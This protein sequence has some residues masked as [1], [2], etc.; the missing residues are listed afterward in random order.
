VHDYILASSQRLL[1]ES[2]SNLPDW[3]AQ[4][5]HSTQMQVQRV[6][7]QAC[8]LGAK[9]N[10]LSDATRN[11][12]AR[13]D[14]NTARVN[15]RLAKVAV[16]VTL[17]VENALLQYDTAPADLNVAPTEFAPPMDSLATA[18]AAIARTSSVRTSSVPVHTQRNI[19]DRPIASVPTAA[20]EALD[21]DRRRPSLTEQI[22]SVIPTSIIPTSILP[23]SQRRMRSWKDTAKKASQLGTADDL[24]DV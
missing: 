17:L 8:E 12:L 18:T 6:H 14:A 3:V 1:G 16:E 21:P 22:Q 7:E 20:P 2:S 13:V 15:E 9:L 24:E 4:Q 10:S 23:G 19:E 11:G 5:C